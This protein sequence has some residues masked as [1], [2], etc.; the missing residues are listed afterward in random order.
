[1]DEKSSA[2]SPFLATRSVQS[3]PYAVE[4]R[5]GELDDRTVGRIPALCIDAAGLQRGKHGSARIERNFAF[6]RIATKKDRH[7][8]EF[9]GIRDNPS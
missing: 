6:G 8:A 2:R 3:D 1:M 9:G 7:P 5:T 4:A